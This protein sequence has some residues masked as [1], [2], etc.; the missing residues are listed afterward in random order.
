MF[1]TLRNHLVV[2]H[3]WTPASPSWSYSYDGD[4]ASRSQ[5]LMPIIVN[6]LNHSMFDSLLQVLLTFQPSHLIQVQP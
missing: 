3:Q 5:W 6:L 4:G 2:L 1:T